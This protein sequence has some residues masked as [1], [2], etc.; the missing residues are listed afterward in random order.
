MLAFYSLLRI[1]AGLPPQ[2]S[3]RSAPQRAKRSGG[4]EATS[5]CRPLALSSNG[6][7]ASYRVLYGAR[8]Q[9]A[10]IVGARP[11]ARSQTAPIVGARPSA[12]GQTAPIVGARP[13]ARGVAVAV[14]PHQNVGRRHGLP[15]GAVRHAPLRHSGYSCLTDRNGGPG[16]DRKRNQSISLLHSMSGSS[17]CDLRNGLL[18]AAVRTSVAAADRVRDAG[19]YGSARLDRRFR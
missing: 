15:H 18:R 2:C 4:R 9:T 12:R 5:E 17:Y 11:S 3:C 16:S 7:A 10:A 8:S 14:R 13:S 6:E 1:N 19:G